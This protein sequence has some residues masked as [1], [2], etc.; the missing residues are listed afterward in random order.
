MKT[1]KLDEAPLP[2]VDGVEGRSVLASDGGSSTAVDSALGSIVSGIGGSYCVSLSSLAA[3]S[4]VSGTGR[5]GLK[6]N[7]CDVS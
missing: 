4:S 5:V 6:Q 1:L 3:R 2:L 7:G